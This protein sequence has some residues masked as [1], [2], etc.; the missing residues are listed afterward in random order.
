LWEFEQHTGTLVY[1][2]FVPLNDALEAEIKR[3]ETFIRDQLGDC[4]SF[5]L[6][7][8]KSRQEAID[9]LRMM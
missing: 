6:D 9:Q 1:A 3:T 4:R 5:S 8:P 2:L 7:S